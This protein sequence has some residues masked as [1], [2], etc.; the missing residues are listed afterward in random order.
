MDFKEYEDLSKNEDANTIMGVLNNICF[1]YD[2]VARALS[3]QH[4]TL[5][6]S[7]MRLAMKFVEAEA[8]AETWDARNEATVQISKKI[9][10]AL[11]SEIAALPNI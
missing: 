11:G 6:Q 8:K 2:T 3:V 4:R 9:V 7:F 1:D 10:D 5:Q